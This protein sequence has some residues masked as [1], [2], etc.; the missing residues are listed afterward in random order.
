M[1]LILR[2]GAVGDLQL[3][4][5][6]DAAATEPDAIRGIGRDGRVEDGEEASIDNATAKTERVAIR[7][8]G[9]VEDAHGPAIADAR[10]GIARDSAVKELEGPTI[11][12]APPTVPEITDD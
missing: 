10:I 2:D 9:T 3:A 4:C 6:V 1:G 5:I 12:D 8:D 7:E 11:Y